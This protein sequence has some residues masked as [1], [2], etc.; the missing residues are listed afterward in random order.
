MRV[1]YIFEVGQRNKSG[2]RHRGQGTGFLF[3]LEPVLNNFVQMKEQVLY[4]EAL[5]WLLI[6]MLNAWGLIFFFFTLLV[7][8]IW[9]FVFLSFKYSLNIWYGRM[10]SYFL[11]SFI[12]RFNY[13][14]HSQC[15]INII[16][17]LPKLIFNLAEDEQQWLIL[18]K[19]CKLVHIQFNISLRLS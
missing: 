9:K 5:P 6:F 17:E 7:I 2:T 14:Y 3:Q 1:G 16:Q 13:S 8:I 11:Y 12:H 10:H 19:I 15:N 18:Q 4:T